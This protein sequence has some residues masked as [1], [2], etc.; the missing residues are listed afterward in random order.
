MY[1]N[2]VKTNNKF[3]IQLWL[4]LKCESISMNSLEK[5]NYRESDLLK[6]FIK[7]NECSNSEFVNYQKKNV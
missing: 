7:Y 5:V 2:Q 1:A 4:D 6:F 3:R